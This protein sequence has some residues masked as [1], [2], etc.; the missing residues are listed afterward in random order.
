LARWLLAGCGRR[1]REGSDIRRR[2]RGGSRQNIRGICVARRV[3]VAPWAKVVV[4]PRP[5]ERKTRARNSFPA[6]IGN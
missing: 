2:G 3:A 4:L 5:P 6:D 1:R